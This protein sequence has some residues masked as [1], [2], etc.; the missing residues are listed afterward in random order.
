MKEHL[1]G[2]TLP[3]LEQIVTAK[4]GK[5]YRAGQLFQALVLD[6]PIADITTLPQALKQ[7][8]AT[9]YSFNAVEIIKVLKSKDGS[10][11]YL[12]K[13]NDDNII[14]GVFIPQNY[15]NT[16]CISTQVGC[17]MHCA[18]CASGLDGFVRNLTVGELA[19]QVYS[20]NVREGGNRQSRAVDNVVLMGAG[21]PLDN[22]D[23]VVE[24]LRL[25]SDKKGLN[26]SLRGITLSTSG[27]A[28]QIKRL[29]D[30]GLP[31]T[32]AISLHNAKDSKR[33][34]LMP[35]NKKYSI[36]EVMAAA[37]YYFNKTRRRISL[38]YALI[39]GKN[40]S[41][42]DA[43]GLAELVKGKDYHINLIALNEYKEGALQ[44]AST[45]S[46]KRFMAELAKKGV[47]YTLR[48]SAGGDI[49]GACGQLRRS[50]LK[51]ESN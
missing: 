26:I 30:E 8:L 25:I 23:N 28:P 17:K 40:T 3:K 1:Q 2:M 11:K 36:N 12:Y 51:G 15:G 20:A 27:I 37:E 47:N 9:D 6:K 19:A 14:E 43:Q 45:A 44:A 5:S 16:L 38:E 32:L 22:Y 48:H 46:I 10:S 7:S 13:L 29:A 49:D 35:I 21:E 42:A 34:A 4:G 31:I 18:F 41:I 33:T 24:F 50:Y 39:E